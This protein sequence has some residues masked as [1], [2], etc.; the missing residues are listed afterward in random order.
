MDDELRDYFDE[1]MDQVIARL[2]IKLRELLDQ[3]P[4][5]VEDYP[6]KK[7]RAEMGVRRRDELQ[8]LYSGTA[9]PDRT[10]DQGASVSEVIYLFREGILALSTTTDGQIDELALR[11]QIRVTLLHE[12]GHHFGLNEQ[13]LEELGYG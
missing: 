6:S 4:L 2:P 9:L 7:M 3:V 10:T 8:G 1:Q 12:L 11:E 5:Y 13:Q